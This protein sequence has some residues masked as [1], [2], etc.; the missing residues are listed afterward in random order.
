MIQLYRV[1]VP[2]YFRRKI[3]ARRL[4]LSIFKYY[5]SHPEEALSPEIKPMLDYLRTNPISMLPYPFQDQYKAENIEVFDDPESGLKYVLL[6]G[7]R[8]YFKR[9][10]NK[11]KIQK[12]HNDLLKE[13]DLQSPHRYLGKNF[14]FDEGEVLVDAGA[15]EGFF[16]LSMVEKASQLVLIEAGKEWIEP[17]HAT[18]K[19][20]KEKV[21][22]LHKFVGDRSGSKHITLDEMITPGEKGIFLKVDIEGAELL[23]LKGAKRILSEQKSL[24]IAICTYHKEQDEKELTAFLSRYPFE[25]APSEGYMLPVFDKKLKAPFFRRGLIRAK[26]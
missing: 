7:K 5:K 13:Q 22:I 17:L 14:L 1:V 26:K 25:M 24:K 6:D 23:L 10:W 3:L 20:W 21:T 11:G 4:P 9:R 12:V 2:K 18:F 19:P 15:A 8:L 16:A